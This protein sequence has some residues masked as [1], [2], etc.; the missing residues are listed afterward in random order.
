MRRDLSRLQPTPQRK[1]FSPD[2]KER[3]YR[4]TLDRM[5][6]SPSTVLGQ[7]LC[8]LCG[9]RNKMQGTELCWICHER[10]ANGGN[11]SENFSKGNPQGR[12]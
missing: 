6:S 4:E 8:K 9:D 2:L 11:L 10:V 3:D 1:E 7:T 5:T 12:D